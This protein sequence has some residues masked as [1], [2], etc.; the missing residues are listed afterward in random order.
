MKLHDIVGKSVTVKYK[1]NGYAVLWLI[2]GQCVANVGVFFRLLLVFFSYYVYGRTLH[3]FALFELISLSVF[4]L[5]AK[6]NRL[7]MI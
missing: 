1:R 2:G 6:S 5:F 3:R 7:N 4:N